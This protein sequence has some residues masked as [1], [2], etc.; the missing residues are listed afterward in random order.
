[1]TIS[2]AKVRCGKSLLLVKHVLHN[3]VDVNQIAVGTFDT[4]HYC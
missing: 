1:M 2:Q 3:A 4:I